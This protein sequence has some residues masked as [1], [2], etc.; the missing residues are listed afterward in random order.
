[1][2]M[3]FGNRKERIILVKPFCIY[4]YTCFN[5]TR[6]RNKS[7]FCWLFTGKLARCKTYQKQDMAFR[8][9]LKSHK[10]SL[11]ALAWYANL[12][13]LDLR[14]RASLKNGWKPQL[15]YT[16]RE[17]CDPRF[18]ISDMHS[19]LIKVGLSNQKFEFLRRRTGLF[20]VKEQYQSYFCSIVAGLKCQFCCLW[21]LFFKPY[22]PYNCVLQKMQFR[23]LV[24]VRM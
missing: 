3:L 19:K 23:P 15:E 4:G 10:S 1:M 13:T 17:I 16:E 24:M 22:F 2:Q 18:H 11:E 7:V 20:Y 21:Y 6:C 8:L 9:N 14:F 5:E 12:L